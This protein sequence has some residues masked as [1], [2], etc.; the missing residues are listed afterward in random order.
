MVNVAEITRL[1]PDPLEAI[2]ANLREMEL[3]LFRVAQASNDTNS[4]LSSIIRITHPRGLRALARLTPGELEQLASAVFASFQFTV[5]VADIAD[6]TAPPRPNT[7]VDSLV[8]Y[9]GL[10][11]KEDLTHRWLLTSRAIC[12]AT[13]HLATVRL[14]ITSEDIDA[15]TSPSWAYLQEIAR[16]IVAT[17][18]DNQQPIFQLRYAE[19][20][21][22]TACSDPHLFVMQALARMTAHQPS[23]I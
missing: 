8:D 17:C 4:E 3:I 23:R 12:V 5:S 18:R 13:P 7:S 14:G 19:A 2:D 11:G 21:L 16:A 1:N 20:L 15:L 10:S 22:P 6:N 9:Q